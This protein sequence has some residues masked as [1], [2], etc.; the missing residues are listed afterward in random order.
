[1]IAV[2]ALS[3]GSAGLLT[4][5]T[6]VLNAGELIKR[7]PTSLRNAGRNANKLY[8]GYEKRV[9]DIGAGRKPEPIALDERVPAEDLNRFD[10]RLNTDDYASN[11]LKTDTEPAAI[12]MNPNAD[13]AYLAH[14]LGHI[15]SA[16][17]DVGSLVRRA[18]DEIGKNEKLGQA[19]L[20]AMVIT[21]GVAAA[22]EEGDNDLD[23]S[24]ALAAATGLPTLIDEGPATKNGLAIMENAGRRATLGQRGKLAGAYLSY[25]MPALVAGSAANL[26]GNQ[27]D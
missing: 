11:A 1:M 4:Y 3:A 9:D 25:L 5:L 14:E 23:S 20:G 8:K 24:I 7:R 18:R 26:V 27:F 22:L 13:E 17:T 19:L 15:A 16:H 10:P 2:S 6:Q 12:W 21:P